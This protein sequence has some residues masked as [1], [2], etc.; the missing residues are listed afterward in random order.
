MDKPVI[1][2]QV[3]ETFFVPGQK[4]GNFGPTLPPAN[5]SLK[6]FRMTLQD[7]GN[8]LLEWEEGAL[9][10]SYTVPQGNLKGC[11]HPPVKSAESNVVQIKTA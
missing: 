9:T 1:Y 7:S 2:A 8:L 3:N 6:N 10:K 5:L 11:Q 4:N